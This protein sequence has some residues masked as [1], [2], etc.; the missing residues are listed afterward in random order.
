MGNSTTHT[1]FSRNE[2]HTEVASQTEVACNTKVGHETE[3]A[4]KARFS[5]Q[6]QVENKTIFENLYKRIEWSIRSQLL[7]MKE[8]SYDHQQ[9]LCIGAV[10]CANTSYADFIAQFQN[11][12]RKLTAASSRTSNQNAKKGMD[13][14]RSAERYSYRTNNNLVPNHLMNRV[15]WSKWKYWNRPKIENR[16]GASEKTFS[17]TPEQ[18]I[19]ARQNLLANFLKKYA[20]NLTK[21]T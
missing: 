19:S 11:S 15:S 20:R 2:N 16:N 17:Y 4:S 14:L 10:R 18:V 7:A 21:Y 6:T 3:I 12:V 13:F 8:P 1:S 5:S 9:F